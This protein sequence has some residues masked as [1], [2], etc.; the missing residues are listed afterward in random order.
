VTDAGR[1]SCRLSFGEE[2]TITGAHLLLGRL[3]PAGLLDVD[4]AAQ[5]D[6]IREIFDR[7]ARRLCLSR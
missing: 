4:G 3:N 7:S 6:R 2:P 5:L 1:R